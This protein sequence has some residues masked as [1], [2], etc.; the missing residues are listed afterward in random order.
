MQWLS[1]QV[2]EKQARYEPRCTASLLLL[3]RGC[4]SLREVRT[5]TI[6]T[7]GHGTTLYNAIRP[8][9]PT[10]GDLPSRQRRVAEPAPTDKVQNGRSNNNNKKIDVYAGRNSERER[11]N[12]GET[13]IQGVH[14]E[15]VMRTVV[16]RRRLLLP[17]SSC[18]SLIS[19]AA[20]SK[21]PRIVRIPHTRAPRRRENGQEQYIYLYIYIREGENCFHFWIINASK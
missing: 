6:G 1:P 2:G 17:P 15:H 20:A 12:G 5:Q 10:T 14:K 9:S 3:R 7:N 19:H 21:G 13:V 8:A 11:E 18:C 4:Y 16:R